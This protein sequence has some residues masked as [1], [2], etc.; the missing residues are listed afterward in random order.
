MST[1]PVFFDPEGTRRKRAN[2]GTAA[3]GVL[4][5]VV[6][7]FFWVSFSV[8][9]LLPKV[10]G[11]SDRRPSRLIPKLPDVDKRRAMF[12]AAQARQTLNKE[13]TK[14]RL[15]LQVRADKSP[16]G[17]PIV[18]AFYAPWIETA[19]LPSFRRNAKN[20]THLMP[21]WLRLDRNDPTKLD[22]SDYVVGV[23]G[24]GQK[25][26]GQNLIE[27]ARAS[28]VRIWPVLQNIYENV[29]D[30]IIV[31][32][33]LDS[34]AKEAAFAANIRDWL[35][36]NDYDGLNLDFE[37]LDDKDYA[38]MP[39][40]LQIL[41]KTLHAA[42]LGLSIDL[43][44]DKDDAQIKQ[45]SENVDL[46]IVMAYDEHSESENAGAI[47]SVDWTEKLM[48]R[49]AAAVPRNKLVIALGSYAYDWQKGQNAT[50]LTYQEALNIASEDRDDAPASDVL[51]F[52]D[53]TRNIHFSYEDDNN[54][55]HDVWMLDAASA[56]N[57]WK[58]ARDLGARGAALWVLGTEDPSVWKFLNK[59]EIG[60]PP[61][62][63]ALKTVEFG[64]S[65]LPFWGT[66]DIL[67]AKGTPKSASRDIDID[68]D[69][70]LIDDE[71]Y[72]GYPSS[73]YIQRSGFTDPKTIA[74][75]F[76]DGPDPTYTPEILDVLKEQGVPATFFVIGRNA[77]TH[78]DLVRRAVDEGHEIGS[79]TFNHPNLDLTTDERTEME[80]NATQ[81][82]IQGITGRTTVL[83]RPPY[84][85]DIE[86]TR[87]EDIPPLILASRLGYVTVAES[88]DPQDWRIGEHEDGSG[89][90]RTPQEIAND[91]FADLQEKERGNVVLLH[92][93]GGD[94]SATVAALKLL[95]PQLRAKGFR[96]VPV[97]ALLRS[98]RD[99]VMPPIGDKDRVLVGLDQFAFGTIF[100]FE[101]VLR[102]SFLIAIGLG[103]TRV[104]MNT[105]L[106]LL[107]NRRR[108]HGDAAYAP[109]VSVLIA[110]Y[111]E[112]KVIGRTIQSI[113]ASDYPV[114]EII[115]VDDG[116]AD[117]TFLEVVTQFAG[118]PRVIALKQE[119]G[120]KAAALNNAL[121][122]SRGEVLVC[123]DADTQLK[124]DAIGLLARHFQDQKIGAVAGN[125]KVGNRLNLLTRWQSIE[126]ITSQNLDRRA[127]ALLNGIS[128]CPGAIGAWRK[129]ALVE[130]GGYLTDTLAE[131]M[132]LTWRLRRA[133]WKIET[134]SD[135]IA[136]TEA[137]DSLPAF[138][139]QRFR[140]AY[141][142]LQCLWKHRG[143]MF[144][145]G[146]FGWLTLPALWLFQIVFQV[147][148]PLV[149][150]QLIY[151]A[152]M[153]LTAW[154]T[155]SE[156]T[157]DW[158]P[159]ADVQQTL[160][161]VGFLYGLFFTVELISGF[162]AYRMDKERAGSLWWMF[163]QR[164]IYRQVMYTVIFKSIIMAIRGRRQ[165]WGKLDRKATVD[166]DQHERT[167]LR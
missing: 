94:R 4:L 54:L 39:Q 144:H 142:T 14:D 109:G 18:A 136:Y 57:Q 65:D 58:I 48:E 103:L 105:P 49:Y 12:Q 31:Q 38:R 127:Y 138:F 155:R 154:I 107:H 52:D 89:R 16:A 35:K 91:V 37:S 92:D 158:R 84:N 130:S 66:G 19:G 61:D 67:Y 124:S 10:K 97:S 2:W 102:L 11:L 129:T 42:N 22:L 40:L 8:V 80:L 29:P 161:Q 100:T 137:P 96:F 153:F 126:Y 71:T 7:T 20:L 76:D 150:L 70:G 25:T 112:E 9:P 74:L 5:A 135:A 79:H 110:A 163:L 64:A 147:L 51:N 152:F 121:S 93:G 34:P 47:A 32:N 160:I 98:N 68:K 159:A 106:A 46:V 86:P 15:N 131:D 6:T 62:P 95:I 151:T 30:K 149:D 43:E 99:A 111:N 162:I 21:V 134:E 128:V 17:S 53:L 36:L 28:G 145:H 78:P 143:A 140:W 59:S 60:H 113:L 141:G 73:Y 167:V 119:N 1:D 118:E 122:Q 165:G 55:P 132:D 114:S 120:G 115:V 166:L 164:F 156:Y 77:E 90:R 157:K 87:P 75:T 146:W 27:L 69:T 123:I 41:R 148:A 83:F 125:V 88:L 133:G 45:L 26:P 3:L 104:V 101:W 23:N 72:N 50:E 82:A 44:S 13:V 116:S 139:K 24:D 117:G 81:R 85:A 108:F 56:F 63:N 33:L